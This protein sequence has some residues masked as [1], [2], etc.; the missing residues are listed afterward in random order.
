MAAWHA[1]WAWS[2]PLIVLNVVIHVLGL[3]VINERIVGRL[4]NAVN[5]RYFTP[6]FVAGMAAAALMVTVLH[7]FEGALWAATYRLLDALPDNRL[8]ML[9]SLSAITSYG[10][11]PIFLDPRW[12]MMGALEALNGMMLF[13]LTTA[14]LFKMIQQIWPLGS[15]AHRWHG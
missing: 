14:F 15:R 3:G 7:A 12:Q 4:S 13:G 9:Y 1:D 2:L 10:H 5:R 11:A 6:S 8:A